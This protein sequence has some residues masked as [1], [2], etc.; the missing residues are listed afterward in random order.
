MAVCLEFTFKGYCWRSVVVTKKVTMR[1]RSEQV[2]D[3]HDQRLPYEGFTMERPCNF[4]LWLELS[5][6]KWPSDNPGEARRTVVQLITQD[7]SAAS[8]AAAHRTGNPRLSPPGRSEWGTEWALIS[9]LPGQTLQTFAQLRHFSQ[10]LGRPH[11]VVQKMFSF[12]SAAFGTQKIKIC[13]EI[14]LVKVNVH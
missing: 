4:T 8:Y 2:L 10:M 9:T 13:I 11:G 12:R 1:T 3:K 5:E 14:C 6:Y 7:E